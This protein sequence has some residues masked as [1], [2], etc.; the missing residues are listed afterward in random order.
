M[1]TQ[2]QINSIRIIKLIIIKCQTMLILNS[3]QIIE[4]CTT[5]FKLLNWNEFHSHTVFSHIILA[6]PF[7]SLS[8]QALLKAKQNIY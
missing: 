7:G 2:G 8:F 3:V 4:I 1:K 6:A 5:T